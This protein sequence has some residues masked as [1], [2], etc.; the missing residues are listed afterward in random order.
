MLIDSHAHAWP[1]AAPLV[2]D[3]RYTPP[4]AVPAEA[5]VALLDD[6]GVD[7][8]VLVQ[9]SFLGT[10]NSS[11]LDA[12]RRYPDRLRGVAVVEPTITEAELARMD[13][14]G[15][16]GIRFNLIGSTPIPDFEDAEHQKL[17]G[18]VREL[19]WHVEV[20]AEGERWAWFVQTLWAA[21]VKLVADH[22]GRPTPGLGLRCP[23][24][25]A[26]LA[27]AEGERVWFKLS[28][29]YRCDGGNV[30]PLIDVL[31]DRL[32]PGRLVWG[33]DFPWTQ[34]EA[35]QSYAACLEDLERWVPDPLVRETIAGTTAMRLF[36]FPKVYDSF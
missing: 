5:Y 28:A 22:F 30:A 35:G 18:R 13:A 15:V 11:L 31:L 36:R 25:Q 9:P 14:A 20:H 26:L 27:V 6:H 19:G 29:P 3:R 16:V 4:R 12:L 7:G 8:G 17:L 10:D 34:H 33:S 2:A 21:R 32:G 1:A 24:F 23:G